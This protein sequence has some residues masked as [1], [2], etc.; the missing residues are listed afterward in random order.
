MPSVVK[1]METAPA[2]HPMPTTRPAH[3]RCFSPGRQAFTLL[4]VLI[5][6]ALTAVLIVAVWNILNTYQAMFEKGEFVA[7]RSQLVR[8]LS[9]QLSDDLA[10]AIQDPI[11]EEARKRGPT[12]A[13]RFGLYGTSREL[14]IDV[15]QIPPF[16]SGPTPTR[17]EL[18]NPN[19]IRRLQAPELRTVY[20]AFAQAG[21]GAAAETT[22]PAAP[23]Q[24]PG[25]T[26]RELDFETPAEPDQRPG[27]A[28][29]E[30][31]AQTFSTPAEADRAAGSETFD[32][33]ADAGMDRSVTW[34]PEVVAVGF[35]YFD[36]SGW[37]SDWDSLARKGLP[38]AV[39]MT[40]G[41][42]SLDEAER[43][44]RG[45]TQPETLPEATGQQVPG[46]PTPS[47]PLPAPPQPEVHRLVVYLPTS[48]LYKPRKVA[49]TPPR[50]VIARPRPPARAILVP[51]PAAP[52]P[53]PL[54][55]DQWMR[56]QP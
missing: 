13:R 50:P 55:P 30:S 16:S 6:S 22:S 44:R 31:L 42:L 38:V 1:N 23:L 19:A 10:A 28:G 32:A 14:R 4:E 18:E 51:R 45:A 15:L 8:S 34:I 9:Q 20:Y 11:L 43:F 2:D 35:R 49:K 53:A 37:R 12:G 26:R 25:L 39:E 3:A 56:N 27:S 5:A 47:S 7:E 40:F 46:L 24:R 36:G 17:T 41:I 48:P 52:P 21:A 54:S 29:G 33:M